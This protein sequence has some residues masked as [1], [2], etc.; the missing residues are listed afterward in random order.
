MR[1][2]TEIKQNFNLRSGL[3]FSLSHHYFMLKGV[4][5]FVYLHGDPEYY[6]CL[7]D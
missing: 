1:H 4:L 3:L 2:G 6:L 5:F 7:I